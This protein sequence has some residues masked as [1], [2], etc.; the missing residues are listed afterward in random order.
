MEQI[1]MRKGDAMATVEV[2]SLGGK[3]QGSVKI[4]RASGS[5]YSHYHRAL[6][7]LCDAPE[8]AFRQAKALAQIIL[9]GL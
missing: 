1:S 3:Y 6:D 8:E 2:L 7:Q 9:N 4:V 5:T